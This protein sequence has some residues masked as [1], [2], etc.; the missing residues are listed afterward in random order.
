LFQTT[1]VEISKEQIAQ[2]SSLLEKAEYWKLQ[3]ED[4][5]SGLDGAQWILEGVVVS[6]GRCN[7]C[8]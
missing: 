5:T 8:S 3:T 6:M 2:F 7:T 1:S 4:T